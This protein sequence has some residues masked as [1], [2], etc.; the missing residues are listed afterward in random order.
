M[1]LGDQ[2][3]AQ[4]INVG[5]HAPAADI[6]GTHVGTRLLTTSQ[7][8]GNTAADN[9]SAAAVMLWS[10]GDAPPA[11]QPG[12]RPKAKSASDLRRQAKR[13]KPNVPFEPYSVPVTG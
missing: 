10:A 12:K 6:V 4:N 2:A 1:V 11:Q 9:K 3:D 8:V 13:S 7:R 5:T